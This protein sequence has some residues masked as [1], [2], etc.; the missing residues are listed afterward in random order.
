MGYAV[1]IN[2]SH[3]LQTSEGN[4]LRVNPL[5]ITGEDDEPLGEVPVWPVHE[6]NTGMGTSSTSG[7]SKN[8]SGRRKFKGEW[9]S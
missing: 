6:S 7:G 8:K 3:T 1:L 2:F 5:E 9:K 4:I